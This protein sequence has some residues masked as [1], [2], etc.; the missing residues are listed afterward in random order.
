MALMV[1]MC[2][3]MIVFIKI[4]C[5]NQPEKKSDSE[6]GEEEIQDEDDY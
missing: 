1:M 4:D 3:V 2:P 5:K 6:I